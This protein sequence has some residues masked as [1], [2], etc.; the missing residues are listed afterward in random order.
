MEINEIIK[1]RRESLGL[2]TR[3]LADILGV[4]HSTISRYETADIKKIGIDKLLPLA[5]AL[6]CSP[7][8][9]MGYDQDVSKD[10]EIMQLVSVLDD[11][12]KENLKKY[13]S[14]MLL[15]QDKYKKESTI[16]A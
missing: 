2:T 5:R 12:D 15:S 7:A 11:D 6:K 9:L 3:D 16:T 1:N 10:D 13:I 14:N 8:Y 4:S